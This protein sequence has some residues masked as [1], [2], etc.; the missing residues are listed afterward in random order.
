MI[1]IHNLT[2]EQV[3]ML[4]IMWALDTEEDYFT[5]YECLDER[6]RIMA[7]TLQRMVI[8]AELDEL[9]VLGDMQEAKQLLSKF[10]L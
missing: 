7:D 2:V 6:D 8:M 1:S 5:W 3:E 10:V 9:A 4:D